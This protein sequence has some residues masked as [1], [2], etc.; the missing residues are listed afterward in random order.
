MPNAL[1]LTV[2]EDGTA[3]GLYSE[4]FSLNELGSVAIERW[5]NIEYNNEKEKWEVELLEEGRVG[6]SC[7]SRDECIRWEHE[8]YNK[9]RKAG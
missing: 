6:F 2:S 7:D 3:Q 5:S 1:M 8:Y 9:Q 4:L